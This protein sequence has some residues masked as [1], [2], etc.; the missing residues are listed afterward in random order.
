MVHIVLVLY[1]YYSIRTKTVSLSFSKAHDILFPMA[2]SNQ[3]LI[4]STQA[5]VFL[6]TGGNFMGNINDDFDSYYR[7][8]KTKVGFA[9]K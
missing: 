1:K 9:R 2:Q 3:S 8:Y 6:H 7:Y 4:D 5:Y